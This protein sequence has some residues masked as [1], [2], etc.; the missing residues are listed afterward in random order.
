MSTVAADCAAPVWPVPAPAAPLDRQQA[1]KALS[2]LVARFIGYVGRRLPQDVLDRL[3]EL[4][5]RDEAPPAGGAGEAMFET[6][7]AADR[8]D[9]LCCQDSGALR[10]F[11][12]A[13]AGFPLRGELEGILGAVVREARREAAPPR[14][15]AVEAAGPDPVWI[16]WEFV[17]DDDRCTIDV[18]MAGGECSVPASA[19]ILASAAGDEG[20]AQFVLDGVA[21]CGMN[22]CPPLQVGVG[23]SS[24]AESA[25]L[26]SRRAL[27]RPIGSHHPDPRMAKLEM[28]LEQRLGNVGAGPQRAARGPSVMAVRVESSARQAP[29]HGVGVS[30]GCWA[31]RRGTLRIGPDL[32]YDLPSHPGIVL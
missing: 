14:H 32:S 8:P 15:D 30:V 12:R 22:A 3:A 29:A 4:R 17:P 10:V 18:C 9:R 11:V 7:D 24:S 26:L 19:R 25:A 27:L 2:D 13:G 28:L 16:E 31:H 21:S 6:L 20:V 1:A 5:A 23:L